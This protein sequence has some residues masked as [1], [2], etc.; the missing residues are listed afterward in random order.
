[1]AGRA[2]RKKLRKYGVL[3]SYF[4][5]LVY[6]CT[7]DDNQVEEIILE[8]INSIKNCETKSLAHSALYKISEMENDD[9]D[10]DY[11]IELNPIFEDNDINNDFSLECIKQIAEDMKKL[12]EEYNPLGRDNISIRFTAENV[13]EYG[14]ICPYI[15]FTRE[16]TDEEYKERVQKVEAVLRKKEQAKEKAKL[17]KAKKIKD[18]ELALLNKLAKKYGK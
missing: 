9:F 16:E 10:Y 2:S 13:N 18:E 4:K 8:N 12:K 3:K 5:W 6:K 11:E 15:Y 17:E 14:M 7:E 1:M